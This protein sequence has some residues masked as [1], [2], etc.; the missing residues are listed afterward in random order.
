MVGNPLDDLD[1]AALY[2][3]L[4][5]A[6]YAQRPTA[7]DARSSLPSSAEVGKREFD[8]V[9][10][11]L[12]EALRQPYFQGIPARIASALQ[13]EASW[14]MPTTVVAALARHKGMIIY[15]MN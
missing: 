7:K 1:E 5:A 4:G 6:W 9:A 2:E 14:R 3:L 15:S 12:T 8:A 10:P 11:I 13:V